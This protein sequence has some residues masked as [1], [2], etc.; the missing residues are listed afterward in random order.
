M[1]LPIWPAQH[2]AKIHSTNP[3]ERLNGE[4]KHRSDV[5]GIF[6]NEAAVSLGPLAIRMGLFPAG[7]FRHRSGD[8]RAARDLTV[9]RAR[10]GPGDGRR[11]PMVITPV[12]LRA[13]G[14]R[15]E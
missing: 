10:G 11:T 2:R 9:G 13:P 5:V 8:H 14:I 4:I 1:S 15:A 6:H 7:V 12:G 3:L